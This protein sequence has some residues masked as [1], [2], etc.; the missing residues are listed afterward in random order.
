MEY[1]G[2]DRVGGSDPTGEPRDSAKR[3]TMQKKKG[4]R[5]VDVKTGQETAGKVHTEKEKETYSWVDTS[6]ETEV[7]ISGISRHKWDKRLNQAVLEH[8]TASCGGGAFWLIHTP[9]APTSSA[10]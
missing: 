4:R 5:P 3:E 9:I 2:R 6:G 1:A 10:P 8:S 7:Q